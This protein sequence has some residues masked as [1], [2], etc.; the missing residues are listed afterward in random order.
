MCIEFKLIHLQYPTM[1]VLSVAMV[2]TGLVWPYANIMSNILEAVI[3]TDVLILLFIRNTTQAKE[4]LNNVFFKK[5]NTTDSC[6]D[7]QL[8]LSRLSYT[9]LPFY[10]SPLLITLIGICIW[11]ACSTRYIWTLIKVCL[12]CTSPF[13]NRWW[14]IKFSLSMSMQL[15]VVCVII[16]GELVTQDIM[17]VHS[18]RSYFLWSLSFFKVHCR[19]YSNFAVIKS[20]SISKIFTSWKNNN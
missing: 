20:T 17:W 13:T 3:C 9:L 2:I 5:L 7:Y 10:Y 14:L 16:E 12:A 18:T 6:L 19:H 1:L 8:D 4:E 15:I 11:M